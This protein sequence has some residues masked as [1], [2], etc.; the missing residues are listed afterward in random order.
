MGSKSWS[1]I[2]FTITFSKQFLFL[3]FEHSVYSLMAQFNCKGIKRSHRKKE[4]QKFRTF[5]PMVSK[6]NYDCSSGDHLFSKILNESF[7]AFKSKTSLRKNQ[8]NYQG[9]QCPCK[10]VHGLLYR[11]TENSFPFFLY[12]KPVEIS[13]KCFNI[14]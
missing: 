9:M 4:K 6:E 8:L 2:T 11:W 14:I 12:L 13:K 7:K 1:V 10:I 3:S 5:F